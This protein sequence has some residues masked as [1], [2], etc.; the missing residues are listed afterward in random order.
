M[1]TFTKTH[2]ANRGTSTY[3]DGAGLTIYVPKSA[4]A[5]PETLEITGLVAPV[6]VSNR[7]PGAPKMTKEEVK[8]ARDVEKARFAAL[9]PEAKAQE[10]RDKAAAK[11]EAAAKALAAADAR[12][13]KI[14]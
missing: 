13:K 2:T 1:A 5:H 10:M 14:A 9:S 6:K 8:A 11:R 7:K 12:L 4:G 3:Q